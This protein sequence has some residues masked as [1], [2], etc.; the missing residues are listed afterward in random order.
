MI[1]DNEKQNNMPSV[2]NVTTLIVTLFICALGFIVL[3]A[4]DDA[5]VIVRTDIVLEDNHSVAYDIEN[6]SIDKYVFFQ[7]CYAAIPDLMINKWDVKVI[8]MNQ[9]TNESIQIPTYMAESEKYKE[10]YSDTNNTYQKAGFEANIKTDKL[11][12]E[13]N[14]YNIILYYNNNDAD[15]YIDTK[16]V[17]T[18]KGIIK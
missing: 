8:L 2:K 5:R 18:A 15:I 14:N 7:N 11:E 17:L 6:V 9:T 1:Q 4:I 13:N 10:Q 3:S 12:L 16:Y